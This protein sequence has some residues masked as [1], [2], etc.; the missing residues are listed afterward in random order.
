VSIQLIQG[1]EYFW[2]LECPYEI[3][4]GEAITDT[5]V[6]VAV[7]DQTLDDKKVVRKATKLFRRIQGHALSIKETRALLSEAIQQWNSQQQ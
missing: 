7:E 3:A 5:V 4:T 6:M 2:G 1:D